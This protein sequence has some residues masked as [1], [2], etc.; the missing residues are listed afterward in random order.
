[1]FVLIVFLTVG[2]S[3]ILANFEKRVLGR[4]EN[5][6]RKVRKN[7]KLIQKTFEVEK[8]EQLEEN[9][10]KLGV[11]TNIGMDCREAVH[12]RKRQELQA[13]E[14]D[15]RDAPPGD[16]PVAGR[17]AGFQSAPLRRRPRQH[18]GRH[19]GRNICWF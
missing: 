17:L 16:E 5:C 19:H 14:E 9:P 18:R 1:M 11:R 15:P 3:L 6:F 12:E 4:S 2:H 7:F 10:F 13:G 8:S